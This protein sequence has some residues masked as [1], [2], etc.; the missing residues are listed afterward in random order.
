M[1]QWL[2]LGFK[3]AKNLATGWFYIG[4]V[5]NKVNAIIVTITACFYFCYKRFDVAF[6]I[7][8]QSKGYS[9]RCRLFLILSLDLEEEMTIK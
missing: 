6:G 1:L 9:F 8:L 5:A 3:N 4:F 7:R 2:R